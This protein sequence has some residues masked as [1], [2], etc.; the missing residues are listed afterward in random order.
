M[1]KVCLV[2]NFAD[3]KNDWYTCNI[4]IFTVL[5]YLKPLLQKLKTVVNNFTLVERL[6]GICQLP[7]QRKDN[8]FVVITVDQKN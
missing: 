4:S 3:L 7:Y 5:A 1:E 2:V 8:F 6:K